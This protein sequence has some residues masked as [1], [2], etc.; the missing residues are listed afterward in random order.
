MI[1]KTESVCFVIV[2]VVSGLIQYFLFQQPWTESVARGMVIGITSG[3]VIA[4]LGRKR[5]R[6]REPPRE[7]RSGND[8]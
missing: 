3:A 4:Y 5:H 8:V 7:H 2:A 1:T 6:A